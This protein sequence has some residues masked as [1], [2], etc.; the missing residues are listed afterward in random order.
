MAGASLS[1]LVLLGIRQT[2]A[3]IEMRCRNAEK[4]A[5]TSKEL[6][7]KGG[8]VSS[9]TCNLGSFGQIKK[10]TEAI[11]AD[12]TSIDVLINNAGV[13]EECKSKSEDG[14]EMTWAINVLAPFLLTSLLK[15]IITTRIINVSS[16]SAGSRMDF[17]NLQQVI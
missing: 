12:F 9:Y 8:K 16:I 2:V 15:D 4:V 10:L 6:S 1:R 17:D 7:G 13:F 14:F 11:K 3:S 5:A